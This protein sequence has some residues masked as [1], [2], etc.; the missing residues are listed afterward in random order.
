MFVVQE[1]TSCLNL[2]YFDEVS[3]WVKENFNTNREGDPVNYSTQLAIHQS[4]DVRNITQ[5]YA[6]ALAGTRQIHTLGNDWKENPAAIKRFIAETEKFDV[7][8][9]QDWKKVF[10]EV[11]EFYK[12]YL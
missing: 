2:F 3:D 6:D 4:L 9:A 1:T 12:R 10:P 8:R 11:A 7:M 5:E